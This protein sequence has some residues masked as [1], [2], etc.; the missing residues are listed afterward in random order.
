M[1]RKITGRKILED[2]G[3]AGLAA[4]HFSLGT[5]GGDPEWRLLQDTLS[6]RVSPPADFPAGETEFRSQV[7]SQTEFGTERR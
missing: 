3:T 1:G 2:P 7:R 4:G 5:E 6:G